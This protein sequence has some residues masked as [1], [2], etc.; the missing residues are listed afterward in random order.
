MAPIPSKRRTKK[1]PEPLDWRELARGPAL[2]GLTDVLA[3]PAD[4]ARDRAARRIA[5]E[6]TGEPGIVLNGGAALPT[7]GNTPTEGVTSPT[8]TYLEVHRS[9]PPSEVATSTG[10]DKPTEG[11][12]ATA[13]SPS[14]LS[15]KLPGETPS[16]DLSPSVI[17][18][19]CK[20]ED[21]PSVGITI[22]SY[23]PNV[24][25]SNYKTP[26]VGLQ[27]PGPLLGRSQLSPSEAFSPSEGV[28]THKQPH[29]Y[30]SPYWIDSTGTLHEGRRIHKVLI[31][32]QSMTLGEERFYHSVWHAKESDG[33]MRESGKSKVFSLGYDRLARMVR[34]DE[35]SVRLLIPK[36]V[37]KKI[38]EILAPEVSASQVG[39]T[40]RIFS[41][42]EILD[43]QRAANLQF[44]VKKGRAVEFVI[45]QT[46]S[47]TEGVPGSV[48]LASAPSK[49][50]A[51]PLSSQSSPVFHALQEFGVPG[52]DAVRALIARCRRNDP[53]ATIEEMVHFIQE[54]GQVAKSGQIGNPIA[55]LMVYVPK[56]FPGASLSTYREERQAQAK[57]LQ[58]QLDQERRTQQ[59]ILDDPAA[60]DE[61]KHWASHFLSIPAG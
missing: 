20:P 13:D 50:A 57:D 38:L 2:R 29:S 58:V 56:C 26:S 31:A 55:F 28:A 47:P 32:Q 59:A 52:D 9:V 12:P 17:E 6:D 60:S 43:R 45:P 35:K 18:S 53:A 33:V 34:L 48:G 19:L 49:T 5:L 11:G 14:L 41:Y 23:L 30:S 8:S 10:V 51:D 21:S 15:L 36:L 4:V 37:A 27:S 39:R 3:T 44:I 1:P 46:G 40:Y 24:V 61:D 42:E 54:K 25:T 22:T 16:E 7:M